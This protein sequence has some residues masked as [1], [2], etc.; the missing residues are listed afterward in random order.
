MA[1]LGISSAA[2]V[3][4]E[5]A[6]AVLKVRFGPLSIAHETAS[7]AACVNMAPKASTPRSPAHFGRI[8][9]LV[10]NGTAGSL[11]LLTLEGPDFSSY[12]QSG[13]RET[14]VGGF[15]PIR[16]CALQ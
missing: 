9:F 1:Y 2:Q 15:V 16:L 7:L 10:R 4:T 13:W 14:V 12:T 6:N 3:A 5:A 8:S 11:G